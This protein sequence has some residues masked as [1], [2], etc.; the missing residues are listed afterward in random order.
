MSYDT[1]DT[2]PLPTAEAARTS[3][4][5]QQR[6]WNRGYTISHH[7][8]PSQFDTRRVR[9]LADA[10]R[11]ASALINIIFL[12]RRQRK[13]LTLPGYQTRLRICTMVYRRYDCIAVTL[14]YPSTVTL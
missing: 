6:R 13:Y 5:L 11:Q 12:V 8:A 7:D 10:L 9:P 4:A 14:R 2:G 3:H 1:Y